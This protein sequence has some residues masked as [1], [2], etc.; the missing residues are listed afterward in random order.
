MPASRLQGIRTT[1]GNFDDSLC[2]VITDAGLRCLSEVF[3][4]SLQAVVL[5]G[6]LE[7]FFVT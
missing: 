3:R 7:S 6:F 1:A 2:T 4:W 5:G